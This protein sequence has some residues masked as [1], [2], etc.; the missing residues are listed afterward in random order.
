VPT[1]VLPGA[2]TDI[3]KEA[4]QALEKAFDFRPRN[5]LKG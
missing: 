5:H 2:E 4:Y 1:I 3:Q